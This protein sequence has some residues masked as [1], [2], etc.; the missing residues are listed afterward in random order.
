MLHGNPHGKPRGGHE[1][2]TAR[3]MVAVLGVAARRP[4]C[5]DWAIHLLNGE[6]SHLLSQTRS[7]IARAFLGRAEARAA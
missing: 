1:V 3:A 6:W 5:E 4:G 2:Y 7:G